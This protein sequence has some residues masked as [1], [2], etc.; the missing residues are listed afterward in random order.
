VARRPKQTHV[1]HAPRVTSSIFSILG[2]V[3][4]FT[5]K[6]FFT[7]FVYTF[8]SISLLIL[9]T[10]TFTK[11]L[12]R[13]LRVYLSGPRSKRKIKAKKTKKKITFKFPKIALK[14][15]APRLPT[16]PYVNA[17]TITLYTIYSLIIISTL[18]YF[19]SSLPSP[20]DL[21]NRQL[22][23][24]TKIYDRNGVLLYTIYKDKNRSLVSLS[25]VPKH[26]R[27][28]TL[29]IEDAEFYSHPGFS[30]KGVIRA[31]SK[32]ITKG[33]LTGGSTITQQLVKNALL[34][35]EKT[36][37]RKVKEVILAM[38]TEMQYSKDEIFE[39]Y[40]NEVSYG[41]TVYGIEEAALT[42]FGKPAKDLTLA[43][44]ALL[45][46]LPKSP[47]AYSPFGQNPNS[48][49]VRQREVLHLMVVNKFISK[50]EETQALNEKIT[51]AADKTDIKAPHFVM[52]VRQYLEEKY[53]KEVVEKGGLNVI[54]TLD[55]QVQDIAEEAVKIEIAKLANV[56]VTNGAALVINPQTGEILAMVGSKDYFDFKSDGNVNVI[57]SLRQPGSSI[58]VVNY[59]QALSTSYT[60]ASILSDTPVSFNVRGQEPY[61]P[62]NYDNAFKGQLSLRN[63]LAQSRNIPAVR[64]LASYGVKKM[65]DLGKKMGITTWEDEG[66]FGLSLTLGGG[67]VKLIDLATVYATIANSGKKPAL[68][69]LI[70]VTNYK[71]RTLYENSCIGDNAKNCAEKQV[72]D[73][74]VAYIVTDILKDNFARA[75]AFGISSQLVIKNHPE[76]AVKT[77][78][79]NSLRDNLTLGYNQ[80]YLTAVWVG[81][82]DNSP[83]SRV[84]SGVTGAS[85]IWNRIMTALLNNQKSTEWETPKGLL[86]VPI[87]STTGTLPCEGC[88]IKL[89]WFL[90]EKKPTYACKPT[91]PEEGKEAE[92]TIPQKTPYEIVNV[93]ITRMP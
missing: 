63:A 61:T 50:E 29:A 28:A 72:I 3:L 27:D 38:A 49:F 65:I 40:L 44:G 26:V 64:V 83:M 75:P 55:Y 46:G 25:S 78:T 57:T 89:E 39:M 14:I 43:E 45:A 6:P 93:S 12:K 21:I 66:R 51:F 88:P 5:G 87:C 52:F 80:K 19:F 84:A 18:T 56:N 33:E 47:T 58:K 4:Y 74:R 17:R 8:S 54:T 34:S 60:P 13:F 22:E 35:P 10:N 53:G 36:L 79:S 11:K 9:N 86:R 85:P 1:N 16:L 42:Y 77:G 90:E 71:G 67:E 31:I 73:P 30:I 2:K 82:N 69:P 20:S 32:N 59:I 81:N 48:S 62:K 24:S 37:T 7:V 91:K 92:A 41:G 23:V 68:N 15:T 76:V 70:S